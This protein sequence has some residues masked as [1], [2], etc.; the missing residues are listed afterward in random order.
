MHVKAHGIYSH[1]KSTS[2]VLTFFFVLFTYATSHCQNVTQASSPSSLDW[3][4][5]IKQTDSIF[6]QWDTTVTPGC[7][8]SVMK[9]GRTIYERGYGM[10]DLDHNIP[11]TP[12]T[13]FHVASMSKQFT[14]ASIILLAQEGKLS[15]NDDIHKYLPE[16]PDFGPK[17][18]IENLLHH[19]SGIRDQWE[20]M[21]LAGWR[22]SLDLITDADILSQIYRQKELNFLP[23]SRMLYDNSGY[24][25]M[26]Q[27]VQKVSGQSFRAFTTDHFFT[28][29]EMHSTHFRDDHAEVVKHDAYGY[30]PTNQHN[31]Y[32]LSITN[33]DTVG[34]TGLLTTVEDLAAWDENFYSTRIGGREFIKA[35]LTPGKLDSGKPTAYNNFIYASGLELGTYR[36]LQVVEHSGADAGYRADLVRFPAQHVSFACLCNRSDAV[37]TELIRKVADIFMAK[38]F[39]VPLVDDSREKAHPPDA[40]E[41]RLAQYNGLFWNKE[42]GHSLRFAVSGGRLNLLKPNGTETKLD[43]ITDTKFHAE[44]TVDTYSFRKEVN[45]WHLALNHGLESPLTYIEVDQFHPTIEQLESYAGTYISDEVDP[46]IYITV[47]HGILLLRRPKKAPQKFSPTVDDS[48]QDETGIDIH[49][50][51]DA[52]GKVI[53][54][55]W[56]SGRVVNFHFTRVRS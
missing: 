47:D 49:F 2:K 35:M 43:S 32:K 10:A 11:I 30:T 39:T 53:S 21:D 22:Y 56:D 19:T 24:T 44:G 15:L 31:V 55:L 42:L 41:Q 23:G 40:N 29:L 25:L 20:L 45:K 17:I 37:P 4:D 9:D 34:A 28:P 46:K 51:R 54:L 38:E 18:T 26:A 52:N 5:Q 50:S 3:A 12:Q 8:L 14:A 6:S 13:V 48:F 36:G 7:A 1:R 27:I 16:L 33:F